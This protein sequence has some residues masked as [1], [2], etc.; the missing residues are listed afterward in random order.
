[1]RAIGVRPLR[2]A[3]A[4]LMMT[5]AAAPVVDAR[6][7]RRDR[8]VLGKGGLEFRHRVV[9]RARAGIFVGVDDDVALA[10][11]HGHG[12]NFIPEAACL[13]A[14]SALFLQPTAKRVASRVICHF[15]AMFSAV[16]H[17]IAVKSV[18]EPV[19]K[20]GV[21]ELHLPYS[22]AAAQ[23]GG[24]GGERHRISWP[25]AT[26]MFA[27]PFVICW[28]PAQPPQAAAAQLIDAESGLFLR[29]PSLH[30]RLPCRKFSAPERGQYRESPHPPRPHRPSRLRERS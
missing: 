30:R 10:R 28:S 19:L 1:M 8:P 3:W 17:V 25:P 20:H 11:R 21:D 7:C 14:A 4:A 13:C 29:N 26:M 12:R 16:F 5:D 27:S 15:L 23:I 9:S 18:D 22:D 2:L 24:V 6:T